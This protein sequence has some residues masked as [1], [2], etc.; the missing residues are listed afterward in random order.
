M[1]WRLIGVIAISVILLLFI[2]FNIGESHSC[3]LSLG[4]HTFPNVPV[5]LTVFISFMLGMLFSLPFIFLKKNPKKEKHGK[6][7]KKQPSE[8]S[9]KPPETGEKT[10]ETTDY[11]ID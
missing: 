8:T 2:G 1:P 3:D 4:F 6:I 11:G 5:F 7:W 10:P 9:E